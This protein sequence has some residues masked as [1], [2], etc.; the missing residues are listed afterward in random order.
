MIAYKAINAG[1]AR[2]SAF[3]LSFVIVKKEA[4]F[5]VGGRLLPFVY[6]GNHAHVSD[7]AFITT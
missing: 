6:I 7:Q 4:T 1:E 3:G 2:D 5:L